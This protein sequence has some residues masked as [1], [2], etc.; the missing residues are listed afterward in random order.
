MPGSYVGLTKDGELIG[1]GTVGESGILDLEI[2]QQPLTPGTAR[3]VVMAQN[4]EPYVVDLNVIVPA[5]V[6]IN[7]GTID[8]N[9]ETEISV[10]VF[11]YD[12]VTPRPGIDVWAAGLSYEPISSSSPTSGSRLRSVCPT[13]SP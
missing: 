11:E 3:M 5:T 1:A 10:G 7:P 6:Y 13:R 9:V 12:G 4:H 2:W 8:A